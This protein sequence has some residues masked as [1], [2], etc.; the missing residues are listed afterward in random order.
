[1]E[2]V[3]LDFWSAEDSKQHSVDVLV[4]TDHFTKLAHAFPCPNQTAKQV[5][6]KLWDHVFCVYGFPERIHSDQGANFESEL[7]AELLRLSGVSKSHT[8]AYHPMGN[9]GTER[10]NRTLGNMLR[11]LPLTQKQKWPQQI[12]T[13]T[14]AYNSTV[15]ETTGYAPF[16]LMFGR[17]PRLPVDVMFKQVLNDPVVVDHKSYVKTLMSHLHEAARIAQKHSIKEQDKQAEGYNK[18][19][20]GTH[21]NIGDR[22]LIANKG[23]RG[24]KKLAD[25]WSPTVYTIKDKNSQNHTYK[26]EDPDGATKVVHRN[27]LLDISFLPVINAS[28]EEEECT[29]DFLDVEDSMDRTNSWIM[30]G[31]EHSFN[32]LDQSDSVSQSEQSS[33]CSQ[34]TECEGQTQNEML[35]SPGQSDIGSLVVENDSYSPD[36]Q[37]SPDIDTLETQLLTDPDHDQDSPEMLTQTNPEVNGERVVITRAGG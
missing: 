12:Q 7:I 4:A 16:Q 17:I 6:K 22:V 30:S 14:F 1:M 8:T 11:S 10:F 21:L 34:E 13:L 27:L 32:Q 18:K 31:S 25:K 23:E 9:G 5:A 26:L 19:I 35:C 24:K 29:P 20:K 36:T 15:H 3:C 37:L 28:D 33:Y 2:L